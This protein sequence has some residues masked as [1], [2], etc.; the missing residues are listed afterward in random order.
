MVTPN[1]CRRENSDQTGSVCVSHF[2]LSVVSL[3]RAGRTVGRA[4]PFDDGEAIKRFV[5]ELPVEAE[6]EQAT[7]L[8]GNME[9]AILVSSPC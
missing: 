4:E 3:Q 1:G 5:R 6:S 7:P 8:W 9:Y 2:R